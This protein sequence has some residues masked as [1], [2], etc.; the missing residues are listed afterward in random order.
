MSS[1]NVL[2]QKKSWKIKKKLACSNPHTLGAVLLEGSLHARVLLCAMHLVGLCF[3]CNS[4]KAY[5]L[6]VN[7][8]A[9]QFPTC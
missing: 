3:T 9:K 2:L 6:N 7:E 1:Q 4:I 5:I 8:M